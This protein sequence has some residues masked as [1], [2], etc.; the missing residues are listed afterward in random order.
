MPWVEAAQRY[1]VSGGNRDFC[2]CR[3]LDRGV[4]GIQHSLLAIYLPTSHPSPLT[5]YTALLQLWWLS[6]LPERSG[7]NLRF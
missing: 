3:P 4:G 7:G 6:S 2:G 5:L 1:K